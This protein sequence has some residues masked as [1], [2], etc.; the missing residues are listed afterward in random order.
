VVLINH[1]TIGSV[2]DNPGFRER[3]L[4]V[5]RRHPQIRFILDSRGYHESYRETMHKLNDREVLRSCGHPVESVK[6]ITEELLLQCMHQLHADWKSPLVVTRGEHG[7]LVME[8]ESIRQVL[9]VQL[10]GPIDPVGAGDTFV[11]ALAAFLAAGVELGSAAV[12]ANLAAAL[13]V[14]KL[15]QTGTVTREEILQLAKSERDF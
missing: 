15:F 3:L 10:E 2:H 12:I 13:T 14:Q 5:I 8:G 1:Q 6:E 11:S 9:G 4:G 7:C